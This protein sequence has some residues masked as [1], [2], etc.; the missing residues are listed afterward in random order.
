MESLKDKVT[1][2]TGGASGLFH[3]KQEQGEERKSDDIEV[4]IG[5]KR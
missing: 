1:L 5:R 3:S 2:V 4:E